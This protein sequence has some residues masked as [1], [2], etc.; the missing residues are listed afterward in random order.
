VRDAAGHRPQRPK[1]LLLDDLLLGIT[2][3]GERVFQVVRLALQGRRAFFNQAFQARVVVLGLKVQPAG[4]EHVLD[5][6]E[7]FQEIQRFGKKVGG[8]RLQRFVFGFRSHV[9]G[10]HQDRGAF[11]REHGRANVLQDID[12]IDRLHVEVEKDDVRIDLAKPACRYGGVADC[13]TNGVSSPLE[14]SRQ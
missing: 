14:H 1:P 13:D 3:L 11:V 5:P 12:A 6:Q 8:S 7:H 4:D 9:R 2:Q 10:Q